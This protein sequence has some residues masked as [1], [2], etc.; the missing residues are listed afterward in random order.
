MEWEIWGVLLPACMVASWVAVR[1]PLRRVAEEAEADRARPQFRRDREWLEAR[2]LTA[3][4]RLD[5]PGRADWDSATWRDEVFWAR[6]RRTRRFLALVEVR[7]P[8]EPSDGAPRLHPRHATALF[9]YRKRT[10]F[11]DGKRID[12]TRPGEALL[13]SGRFEYIP[14]P[15]RRA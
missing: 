4:G 12:A 15:V 11:A 7:F 1:K 9:E 8:D 13:P 10:W 6:D 2:F 3:L 14:L 5:S